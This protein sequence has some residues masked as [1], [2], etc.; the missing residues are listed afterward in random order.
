MVNISGGGLTPAIQFASL[1][2]T[3]SITLVVRLLAFQA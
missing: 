3:F 1:F 2:V